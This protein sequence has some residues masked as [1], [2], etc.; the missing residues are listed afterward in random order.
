MCKFGVCEWC[1]PVNSASAIELAHKAGFDGLQ[2]SDLG[3]ASQGFPMNSPYVQEFYLQAAS[4]YHIE[5]QSFHPYG[6]QREGTMLFPPD[7][8]QGESAQES[9]RKCIDACAEMKIPSL[10]VSS[11]FAT[12]IRNRWEFEV[13]AQHLKRAVELG[14]EKGV[15]I[16]Y[17]TILNVEHILQMLEIVGPDLTLC[18]DLFNPLRYTLAPPEDL[19]TIGLEHIDHFHIK[20]APADL[21]GYVPIGEGVGHTGELVERILQTGYNGWFVSENYYTLQAADSRRDLLTLLENDVKTLRHY[22]QR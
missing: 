6:L 5:L 11:F 8:P 10:M 19:F 21:K 22:T 2:L 7:T 17:E 1:L 12:L 18:Y 14:R 20:D 9:I 13:Y 15:R 16:V 3:G 4:D